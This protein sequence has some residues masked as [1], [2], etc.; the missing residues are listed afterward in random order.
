[1]KTLLRGA[2][3]VALIACLA[4]ASAQQ[5]WKWSQTPA[6][7][8][9]ADPAINW[10]TGMAPSAVS[11]SS[12]A[13]M[14]AVAKYRDDVSGRL[15][16]S[17][18]TTAYTVTTNSIYA[19][20][21]AD[22]T[23]ISV[24]IPTSF[25]NGANVTLA[26][27]GGSANPIWNGFGPI[28]SGTLV[29]GTIYDLT[30]FTSGN[31]WVVHDFPG[32]PNAVPIGGMIDFAGSTSPNSSFALA[33]GQCI[34]RSTYATLFALTST[35]YGACDGTTTFA[36]PDL[37]GRVTAGLDNM[38]G[39]AQ[40]RLTVAGSFCDGTV[41]GNACG[42][43]NWTLTVGQLPVHTPAGSISV[44]TPS[45]TVNISDPGHFHTTATGSS[46]ATAA[47]GFTPLTPGGGTPQSFASDT[48]FTGITASFVGAGLSASF[49]GTPI[50]SGNAHPTIPPMLV[51]GKIIR[52]F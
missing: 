42:T 9:T 21:P 39:A 5:V 44:G 30:F 27:D 1:M 2:L 46:S 10:A 37:R 14:S 51:V 32:S 41:L 16:V 36:L 43:Q 20:T 12:R 25:T 24:F 31:V 3:A 18:T 23:R 47:G 17:G 7:N 52:I 26:L 11:P 6:T 40:G 34:S 8:A 49:S 35:T 38:N 4:P 50:G 45:G 19:A 29:A 28:S 33:A 22:G 48:K 13:M 15:N